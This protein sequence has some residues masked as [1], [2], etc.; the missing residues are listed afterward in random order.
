MTMQDLI[1][2]VQ[3]RNQYTSKAE[4]AKAVEGVIDAIK[5]LTIEQASSG[6]AGKL[7]LFG[8]GTFSVKTR[9]A[10]PARTGRNPFTGMS[11]TLDAKP[12]KAVLA[13]KP[14]AAMKVDLPG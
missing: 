11:T 1:A 9:A 14:A 5:S 2:N 10:K 8:F 13:F 7:T 3:Q 12:A 6:A 4:A